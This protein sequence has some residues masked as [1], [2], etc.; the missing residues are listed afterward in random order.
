VVDHTHRLW[1]HID[2]WAGE[3]GLTGPDA[4]VRVSDSWQDIDEDTQEDGQ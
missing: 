2:A 4:V 1:P 3:L